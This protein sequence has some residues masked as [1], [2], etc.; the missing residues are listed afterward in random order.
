MSLGAEAATL[1]VG[2]LGEAVQAYAFTPKQVPGANDFT[3]KPTLAHPRPVVLVHGTLENM[4]F[5]WAAISP[6]LKNAGYCVFA[7]NYGDNWLSLDQRAGGLTDIAASAKEL[8]TFVDKVRLATGAP[9]VDIVGHSQG[10]MMP[11]YYIKR[12]GGATK[13]ARFVGLSPSNHGTTLSGITNLGTQLGLLTSFN[14]L[15]AMTAP[16]LAQ[17]EVGSPFMTALFKAGDTVLGPTYVVIQTKNDEVVTPYANAFLKGARNIT[18][19]DQCPTDTT[20]HIGIVFDGPAIQNVLNAL[21]PNNPFF[22][23][24]CTGFGIGV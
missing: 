18:I 12:L 11:S 10:G 21:G 22:K 13:V 7:L 6:T 2:G 24:T 15:A 5:N 20:G 3:C 14:L 23:A 4:G 1:P 8:S 19:Q 9:K 16:S 17:Q